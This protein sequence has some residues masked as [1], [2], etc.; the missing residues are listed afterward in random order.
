MLRPAA[1]WALVALAPLSLAWGAAAAAY[2][3]FHDD[4]MG[5]IVVRQAEMQSAYEDRLAEARAQLDEVTSRQLLD[6]NSLEGKMHEL[7]SRQARLEQRSAIVAALAAEAAAGKPSRF[8]ARTGAAAE[9]ARDAL[10]AIQSLDPPRSRAVD[11]ADSARAYA[12]A[13]SPA[14]LPVE[15]KAGKLRQIDETRENLSAL[16]Q[17]QAAP[18]PGL[19]SVA[20]NPD[21]DAAARLDLIGRSLDRMESRQMTTLAAIDRTAAG[22]SARDAAIVAEIGLDPTR[23]ASPNHGGAVGGPYIPI[24]V[25]SKAP[26]FDRAAARAARDVAAAGRL[27][28]LMPFLPLRK[29]LD[30]EASLSS[31]F[32]YRI[33]PFLGRPSLH[34]GVD[35]IEAYGAEIRCAGAGRVVHAGPMGGY[36]DM[37]EIDHGNGLTTRY[38]HMSEILVEEGQ[39]VAQGALIGRIGSSGRST[40]PHLHYEVRVDGEPVDPERFLRAGAQMSAAE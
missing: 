11:S 33:D 7:L 29:P 8:S 36:G 6:Q 10:G 16:S 1:V 20:E 13:A 38:A 26:E 34:P 32:G 30:G 25:D 28:A 18:P 27:K 15:P 21:V 35:L 5:A 22:A 3:A 4:L 24:E 40:G 19:A 31:P 37:V 12:P 9:I 17:D 39:E 23:L 14:G 2:L